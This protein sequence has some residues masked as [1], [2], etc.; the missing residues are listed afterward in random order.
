MER[1]EVLEDDYIGVHVVDADK[2]LGFLKESNSNPNLKIYFDEDRDIVIE[3]DET[4]LACTFYR[5]MESDINYEFASDYRNSDLGVDLSNDLYSIVFNLGNIPLVRYKDGVFKGTL[6]D[7]DYYAYKLKTLKG[8]RKIDVAK[9]I[10]DILNSYEMDDGNYLNC[11]VEDILNNLIVYKPLKS[12]NIKDMYIVKVGLIC[13]SL[14]DIK[15][16]T[17]AFEEASSEGSSDSL[18]TNL[19]DNLG[20]FA[21]KCKDGIELSMFVPVKFG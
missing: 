14:E 8:F 18:N 1:Y 3:S 19:T 11:S 16:I 6:E 4:N 13:S 7:L 15:F 10:C 12:L 2:L 17:E 21:V 20:K 9:R 5:N